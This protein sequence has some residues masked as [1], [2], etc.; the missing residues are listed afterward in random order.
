MNKEVQDVRKSSDDRRTLREWEQ[1]YGLYILDMDGFDTSDSEL[2]HRTWTRAEFEHGLAECTVI[3]KSPLT[4]AETDTSSFSA[5]RRTEPRFR[6]SDGAL[7]QRQE[8]IAASS[9]HNPSSNRPN[10]NRHRRQQQFQRKTR[11]IKWNLFIYFPLIVLAVWLL[12]KFYRTLSKRI[13]IRWYWPAVLLLLD[14]AVV[15]LDTIGPVFVGPLYVWYVV[16]SWLAYGL[17]EIKQFALS[18][19]H[20]QPMSGH[21]LHVPVATPF[22]SNVLV[23]GNPL[24]DYFTFSAALASAFVWGSALVSTFALLRPPTARR[25]PSVGD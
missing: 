24:S 22:L 6:S 11:R 20:Q 8:E 21:G 17:G 7:E 13:V 10:Q 23:H 16:L 12:S 19:F 9:D 18:M 25:L 14:A 1:A 5:K 3:R 2:Y 4:L 15:S